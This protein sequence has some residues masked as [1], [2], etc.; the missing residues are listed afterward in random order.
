[1]QGGGAAAGGGVASTPGGRSAALAGAMDAAG[2][3]TYEWAVSL[4]PSSKAGLRQQLALR[5]ACGSAGAVTLPLL[6]KVYKP[7]DKALLNGAVDR[8]PCAT[9]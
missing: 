8:A 5:L 4:A 3:A 9:R 2:A 1:M 7:G 6:V